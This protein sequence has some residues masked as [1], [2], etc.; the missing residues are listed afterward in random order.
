MKKEMLTPIALLLFSFSCVVFYQYI[1]EFILY[2]LNLNGKN[3]YDFLGVWLAF[4]FVGL[5]VW[6]VLIADEADIDSSLLTIIAT[7]IF[8][9]IC[10]PITLLILTFF[11]TIE[12]YRHAR[13]FKKA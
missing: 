11:G 13:E 6:A 9:I 4:S 12:I 7:V 8:A 1:L 3:I 5:C 2:V 10:L